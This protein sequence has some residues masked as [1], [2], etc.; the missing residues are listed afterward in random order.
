VTGFN[1]GLQ[2]AVKEIEEWEQLL[3]L[4]HKTA[5]Y[6]YPE[7]AA[8]EHGNQMRLLAVIKNKL[9][10]KINPNRPNRGG[11]V[12]LIDR[13]AEIEH[14]QWMQWA[15]TLLEKEPNISQDR[16]DRWATLMVPYEQLSE[17]WKEYDREWARHVL[18][19]IRLILEE[20]V[21]YYFGVMSEN[22]EQ[23]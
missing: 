10:K 11:S 5:P 4:N 23:D 9:L 22:D 13:L 18:R 1:N 2:E 12:K 20:D 15:K 3:E 8:R 17:E 19:E 21:N 14:K 6:K 7:E 16:K